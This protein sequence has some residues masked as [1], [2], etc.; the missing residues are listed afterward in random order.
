[1][2]DVLSSWLGLS[3]EMS[4]RWGLTLLHF[5]WQGI[6]IGLVTFSAARLLRNQSA[7]VRYWLHAAALLACPVTVAVT[8]AV[9]QIPSALEESSALE[10]SAVPQPAIPV[11]GLTLEFPDTQFPDTQYPDLNP[12]AAID[13]SDVEVADPQAKS[14]VASDES[15][16]APTGVSSSERIPSWLSATAKAMTLAYA[17]GVVGFLIRLASALWG[18]HRLRA[19]SRPVSDS[20]LLKLIRDQAQCVGL[21]LVPV[22]AWCERIAVPTVI[23]VLRPMI[24]LPATLT[25]G[26]SPDEFSAILSHEMAHIRRYDLWM[27]LL[28]RVI[29]SLLFFHP[30]VWFLSRRLSAE[31]EICCDDLVVRCGHEPMHYAG[32]LLR[33]AELC[34]GVS[35][36]NSLALA[37]TTG[38]PTLL[39]HRVLRLIQASPV[40]R[41][42]LNRRGLFL[43]AS[44]L[45]LVL[46]IFVPVIWWLSDSST[47]GPL[48]SN[49]ALGTSDSQQSP[50]EIPKKE[51]ET[52]EKQAA[53]EEPAST[54]VMIAG[55]VE[56]EDG[57]LVTK[58]GSLHIRSQSNRSSTNLGCNLEAGRFSA[59]VLAG[60]M[61]VAAFVD[62]YAP[63]WTDEFELS[64][65][66]TKDDLVIVLKTGTKKT[67]RFVDE[68]D[69]PVAGATLVMHP[70]IHGETVG[71]VIEL[72]TDID[73]LLTVEH[74]AD[75]LYGIRVYAPKFQTLRT[76]R[77]SISGEEELVQA[78]KRC[79]PATGLIL[80][81]DRTPSAGAVVL[82]CIETL[83]KG[84]N[85][86]AV[87]YS[88]NTGDAGW[89]GQR[90][91]TT[92]A[93]GRFELD[94]LND[95]SQY[96][97][98]IQGTDGSRL[99]LSD[100]VAG[101]VDREITLP[102]RR[103]LMI[104]VTGDTSPLTL[105]DGKPFVVIRQQ[106]TMRSATGHGSSA[107]LGAD[108]P[109]ELDANG[110]SATY[111]GLIIDPQA[112]P[113]SAEV[114]VSLGYG[115]D[116]KKT[117]H[118][119]PQGDTRVTFQ[120]PPAKL[121]AAEPKPEKEKES[122]VL[123]DVTIRYPYCVLETENLQPRPLSDAIAE[124]NRTSQKS[125]TGAVQLPITEQET[126]DKITK[127]AA[128]KHVPEAVRVQLEEILKSGTLP[129][130][131][132]F[133]RFTRFDDGKQMQGV[134]WV[135]LVVETKDGREIGRAHV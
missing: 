87:Y 83:S 112:D 30:V 122:L 60:K 41:L 16:N 11:A 84:P 28:Q 59:K 124:F 116:F 20:T 98:V 27:N 80:N 77:V 50:D 94:Q 18:G 135:R 31:R 54:T 81:S 37:A 108:M 39:E 52:P 61:N 75:T 100:L 45:S 73:G 118:I 106:V 72:K 58:P 82:K 91:A 7:V 119:E 113:N 96:M 132:Y 44:T 109:L 115:N 56:L 130:N 1:M 90:I 46:A 29:E 93:D 23:G 13:P 25:T 8:F 51:G 79:R 103:D 49:S 97:M 88:T 14:T 33:M 66:S 55:R 127:F 67:I 5:L 107:V 69:N 10:W 6:F 12:H 62:G 76:D 114:E 15:L 17:V 4:I 2:N 134:W 48:N 43:L 120:L 9:V 86:N 26:L 34:A 104:T 101:Q 63:A 123:T 42:H 126:R 57:T 64:G 22:V 70:E 92:N 89:F 74:L 65:G 19:I 131:A 24:L 95:D 105:R 3:P 129:P 38:G 128:E 53:V 133:R 71:P 121:N 102:E 125:P 68:D 21:R 32:A 99:V 117:V 85:S 110:G 78:L 36:Q 35:P 40:T 111:E 47:N